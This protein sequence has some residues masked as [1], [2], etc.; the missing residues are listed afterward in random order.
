MSDYYNSQ[1]QYAGKPNDRIKITTLEIE[2]VKRIRAI[3]LEPTANG[4][5]IIGGNN[6]Q[7]KTSVLDAI[8]W[9][10]GGDR[11]KP[12]NAERKDS[13]LPPRIKVTLSNGLVV[14]R[15]G[16]NSSLKVTD[17]N[18]QRHGQQLLNSLVEELALNLPKFMNASDREK[19]DILLKVIGVKD[20]LQAMERREKELY[21]QRL[22]IGRTAEQKEKYAKEMPFYP[23]APEAPVTVTELIQRQQMLLAQNGANQQKRFQLEQMLQNKS[24]MEHDIMELRSKLTMLESQYETLSQD[25]RTAQMTV[26]QLRDESTAEIER[27]IAEIE[28]INIKVRANLDR[29]KAADEAMQYKA[30]YDDLSQQLEE[31]RKARYALLNNAPLPL[32]GL[33]VEDGELTYNGFKWGSISSAQQLKIA[34]A[35]VRALNPQCSF[36]LMDKTEQMDLKTLQEFGTWL[37]E[38]G[39]QVIATRVSTG[40]ECS[41]IIED[42]MAMAEQLPEITLPTALKSW[43]EG[44]F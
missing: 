37:R 13:M 14:E 7:G 12:D 31:A 33:S 24:R 4:L 38:Q 26:E 35:I 34:A 36:V 3:A 1:D 44:H 18:G 16:K 42:G 29:A 32:P 2:N 40:D 43:K 8:A 6:G 25:I 17:P 21:N 22:L 10:L 39:L 30:Q 9:A 15:T 11:L 23:D 20:Q 41:I 19:A 28:R 5:T 27:D